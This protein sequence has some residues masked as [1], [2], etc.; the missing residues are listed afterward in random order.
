MRPACDHLWQELNQVWDAVRQAQHAACRAHTRAIRTEQ[1][2]RRA[3]RRTLMAAL[4]PSMPTAD[5]WTRERTATIL[6][7]HGLL[8]GKPASPTTPTKDSPR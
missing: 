7:R 6:A 3:Y 2:V 4:A 1:Q 5:A 8:D